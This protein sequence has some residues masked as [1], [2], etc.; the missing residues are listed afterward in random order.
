MQT[1]VVVRAARPPDWL[2]VALMSC[3]SAASGGLDVHA[4]PTAAPLAGR[5]GLL[6]GAGTLTYRVSKRNAL[7]ISETGSKQHRLRS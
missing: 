3:R 5:R 6:D 1:L 4:A 2:V 7:I